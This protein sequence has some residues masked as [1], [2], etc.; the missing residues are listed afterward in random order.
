MKLIYYRPRFAR[1]VF[2][3]RGHRQ[4]TLDTYER[5]VR[6]TPNSLII[7]AGYNRLIAIR[8]GNKLT[9]CTQ[10]STLYM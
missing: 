10:F 4:R 2:I 6:V 9:R 5:C 8:M 1:V 7:T 3:G